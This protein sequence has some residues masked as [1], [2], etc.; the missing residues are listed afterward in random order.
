MVIVGASLITMC[1]ALVMY[2]VR[3]RNIRLRRNGGYHDPY[4]PTIV[5]GTCVYSEDATKNRLI[6]Q[7]IIDQSRP[8]RAKNVFSFS[9]FLFCDNTYDRFQP[10]RFYVVANQSSS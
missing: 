2:Q 10:L 3:L 5:G 4:G 6:Y 1:Y 7:R 9:S 8:L